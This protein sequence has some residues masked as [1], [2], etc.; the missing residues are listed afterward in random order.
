MQIRLAA[1]LQPDSIV[2]GEG[3]RTV[4]WTQGCSHHCPGCHNPETHDFNG[5]ALVDIEEV[6]SIIDNLEGQD[7]I[8]FSGGDPFFQARE[9][10]EIA[11]YARKKGYN[12]WSFTGYTLEELLTLSKIKPEVMDFLK[13]ID[14]LVDGKFEIRN[15]SYNMVFAGSSNQRI[16]DVPASLKSNRAVLITKYLDCEPKNTLLKPQGIYL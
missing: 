4:I 11:K 5:G 15:K 2:D 12:I 6:Y 9:C 13:Q 16:L 14:V 3:I 8:T 7:G 10:A 1:Y